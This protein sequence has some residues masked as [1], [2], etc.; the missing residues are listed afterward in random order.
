MAFITK[1]RERTTTDSIPYAVCDN[2]ACDVQQEI[3]PEP[4]S[5]HKRPAGWIELAFYIDGPK[6][7]NTQ[8]VDSIIFCSKTCLLNSIDNIPTAVI[9]ALD[10]S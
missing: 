7:H 10:R 4:W 1:V 6:L 8:F 9:T 3:S 5:N 2:P